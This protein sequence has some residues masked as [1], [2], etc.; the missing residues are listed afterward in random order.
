MQRQRYVY[1]HE[2]KKK[3]KKKQSMKNKKK[4]EQIYNKM[5]LTYT[6]HTLTHKRKEK[7]SSER[8][9]ITIGSCS[10]E[11]IKVYDYYSL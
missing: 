1:L 10:I 11:C 5:L 2:T 7:K 9:K 8:A 4:L 3:K 6:K